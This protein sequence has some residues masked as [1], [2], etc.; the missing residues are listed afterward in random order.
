MSPVQHELIDP[1]LLSLVP[2][3]PD[4]IQVTA[5]S[6]VTR[7][8]LESFLDQYA[9]ILEKWVRLN[10]AAT[11]PT[12]ISSSDPRVKE[13][14]GIVGQAMSGADV[15]A[16][17]AHVQLL[18]LF[19]SLESLIQSERKRGLHGKERNS[20]IAITKA[21][22]FAEGRTLSRCEVLELR[23]RAR[24]WARLAGP[25]VFLLMVYSE[26]A[27]AIVKN[28]SKTSDAILGSVAQLVFS[29][30]GPNVLWICR[31]LDL[32]VDGAVAYGKPYDIKV[33]GEQIR[34]VL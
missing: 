25:S 14:F 23:R 29:N 4:K 13:A 16:R 19:D 24:R 10:R 33:M 30:I 28:F 9:I 27:E 26:A 22:S 11:L 12:N 18:K 5:R 3:L 34:A 17:M 6:L 31:G 15:F 20:T 21:I 8:P 7:A 32:A 2:G 1:A